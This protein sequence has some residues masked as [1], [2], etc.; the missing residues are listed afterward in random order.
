MTDITSRIAL[1]MHETA[2]RLTFSKQYSVHFQFWRKTV[3]AKLTITINDAVIYTWLRNKRRLNDKII[4][5]LAEHFSSGFTY[6]VVSVVEIIESFAAFAGLVLSFTL[7]LQSRTALLQ[8]RQLRAT[9]PSRNTAQ[10]SLLWFQSYSGTVTNIA[11]FN[12]ITEHH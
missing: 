8:L 4:H 6:A 3:S 1:W 10:T 7:V 9:K 12:F 11:K 2:C 5:K